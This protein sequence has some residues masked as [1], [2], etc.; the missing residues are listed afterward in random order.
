M[1][2]T[3]VIAEHNDSKLNPATLNAV[4][5][6]KKLGGDI[7][8]FLAG[9]KA[10]AVAKEASSIPDVKRVIYAQDPK[11]AHQLPGI[12]SWSHP[13]TYYTLLHSLR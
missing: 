7:S 1:A 12:P 3:L 13:Y 2:S 4:N 8:I 11:L 5:A 6:A 10:E 9:E